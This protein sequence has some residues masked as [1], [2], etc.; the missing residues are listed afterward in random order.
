M[1]GDFL[2]PTD[3]PG[4][5]DGAGVGFSFI[6]HPSYQTTMLTGLPLLLLIIATLAF[7]ILACTVF[8]WHPFVVLVIA[9]LTLGLAAGMGVDA[10]LTTF[11]QGGGAVFT[12]IGFIIALGTILGEVL[13]KTGAVTSLAEALLRR[14]GKKSVLTGV[15]LM[16]ALVGIPVF[17]DSG[18]II[19]SRLARSLATR[20]AVSYGA[21]S[22]ALAT[23]L[24]TTHVLVPPTP[25]PLA[26]VGNLGMSGDLGWVILIGL[27]VSIPSVITGWL[28]ARA[29][30]RKHLPQPE[31]GPITSSEITTHPALASSLFPL[32][33]PVVLIAFG[34]LVP[35]L[36]LPRTVAMA[37]AFICNP[38]IALLLGVLSAL[39][40]LG[41]SRKTEW[42]AWIQNALTSAG[43]IILI[44]AAGGAL[45]AV[46]KATPL[47]DEFKTL[48]EDRELSVLLFFPIAYLLAAGLKSAQGSSTASLIITSSILAPL[49]AGMAIVHPAEK[50]LL[51]MSIGAGAMTVSH[52]NDSYFWVINQYSGIPPGN[53]YRYFTTATFF[54]GL[55]VLASSM[56]LSLF[57]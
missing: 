1:R 35:F 18:F 52:A 13:E 57:F 4:L 39:L 17:C 10:T 38:N 49:L 12:S 54:M 9:A 16:G 15:S 27:V 56:L 53:M 21:V 14:T 44:T 33:L 6:L 22:I 36:P 55:S 45:G 8:R 11:V 2:F 23:G 25:G 7:I 5:P 34:S 20:S 50:A 51:V 47:A 42:N 46:L 40:L 30:N 48:V 37:I 19:L 26:A 41:T 28:F 31:G 32:L 3:L 29:Y 24:Y 43:P